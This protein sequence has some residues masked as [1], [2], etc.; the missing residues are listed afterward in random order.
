MKWPSLRH[1]IGDLF[2][3]PM[4]QHL[5]AVDRSCLQSSCITKTK[6][7]TLSLSIWTWIGIEFGIHSISGI[8]LLYSKRCAL[9]SNSLE[10]PQQ[11]HFLW[12]SR[13]FVEKS[14]IFKFYFLTSDLSFGQPW[15]ATLL[16]SNKYD[17][18]WNKNHKV[19]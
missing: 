8:R 2:T 13:F 16:E 14:T 3:S 15:L 10:V 11:R 4:V 7:L 17:E 9:M 12:F 18:S 19:T 6:K 1:L 5:L